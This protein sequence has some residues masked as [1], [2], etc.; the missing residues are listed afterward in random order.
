MKKI[1]FFSTLLIFT[2]T[3]AQAQPKTKVQKTKLQAPSK[4]IEP[5]PVEPKTPAPP[6]PTNKSSNTGNQDIP[7]YSLTSVR[8]KIRTG[9]DNKEFPSQVFVGL[10]T[11][12]TPTGDWS[13]F[14]QTKLDNEMKINSDTEFGLERS[15]QQ[16]G[17]ARLDS[18]QTAG[19]RMFIRYRPNFFADAWKI[20]KVSLVLEFKDQHG[21]LHPSLG[22]KT[23]EFNNAYGFLNNDYQV[24]EC[25]TDGSFSPL[26][27]VIKR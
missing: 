24:M 5:T 1:L 4:I 21:N 10:R 16:Q 12:N 11:K 19:L 25:I 9:S 7:V 23:I 27:A 18:F 3:A 6:P 14:S 17:E 20:E 13:A 8:V 26:T 15:P 2:I 22:N